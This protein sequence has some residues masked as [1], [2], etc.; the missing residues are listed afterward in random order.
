MTLLNPK[1]LEEA[2]K[3][4]EE[5][6]NIIIFLKEKIE[7]LEEK[8]K[9]NS[10]NS[11][12]PP[13]SDFFRRKKKKAKNKSKR[14]QGGQPGHKGVARKLIPV[15]EV[16]NIEICKPVKECDC[17]A[18]VKI[19]DDYSRHQVHELPQIKAIITEYQLYSGIC[20]GCGKVHQAIL[21]IGVPDVMLGPMA[22][23]KIAT[24]T[25][26]YR[27][28]KRAV[29]NLLDDFYGLKISRATVSNIEIKVSEALKEPVEVAKN[30]IQQQSVVNADETGYKEKGQKMWAWAAIASLVAVFVISASRG[31]SVIKGLLGSNFKGILCTDRWSGY[32]WMATIFRQLCWSHLIRDFKKISERSG[33]SGKIGDELLSCA[34]RLFHYWHKLKKGIIDRRK[35]QLLMKPIQRRVEELLLAG[36]TCNNKKTAGACKRILKVKEALWTFV[37]KENIEPT[38]NIAEQILRRIVI[39]RKT[40]FGTQS[41]RGTLYMEQIMTV[42]ASCKLQKRNVLNFIVDAINAHLSRTKAPS[43]I[44][45]ILLIK[46]IVGLKAA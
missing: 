46:E 34:Y 24:L 28:S 5:Q 43:L 2:L 37:E 31:A 4:I 45:D 39:W 25:G 30:F 36:I 16:N 7:L 19:T 44:P 15:E 35:F 18:A 22:M 33:K 29:T 12:K 23:A 32:S 3:I 27:M 38:N 8:L 20:A 9:T 6:N 17:G 40:S 10:N 26:D 41:A 13:S 11:S 1:T 42:V 14:K 21:P